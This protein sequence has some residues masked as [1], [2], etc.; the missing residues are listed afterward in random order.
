MR[1]HLLKDVASSKL[2]ASV[3]TIAFLWGGSLTLAAAA[4]IV[5][6][7]DYFDTGRIESNEALVETPLDESQVSGIIVDQ[8]MTQI[9]RAFMQGFQKAWRDFNG[10]SQSLNVAVYERPTAR[11]GSLVWVEQNFVRVYQTFL[12]PGRGNPD[13][14]G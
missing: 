8:T 11:Y 7:K 6:Q 10:K 4:E 12:F 14:V 3:F 2:A 1:N 9:G 5:G 13:A